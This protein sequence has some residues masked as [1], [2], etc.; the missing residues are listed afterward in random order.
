[1]LLNPKGGGL[2][3]GNNVND[4]FQFE[5]PPGGLF[6]RIR[7]IKIIRLPIIILNCKNHLFFILVDR[8]AHG[9]IVQYKQARS[10]WKVSTVFRWIIASASANRLSYIITSAAD[11]KKPV[12]IYV[13]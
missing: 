3:R 5:K 10:S 8:N 4:V 12:L 6:E 9:F 11:T 7:Y 2:Y 13:I 1:M